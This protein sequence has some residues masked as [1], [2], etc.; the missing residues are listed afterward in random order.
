[1]NNNFYNTLFENTVQPRLNLGDIL[2][3]PLVLLVLGNIFYSL[4]LLLKFKILADTIDSEG[5]KKLKTL[6]YINIVVATI[7]GI[8]GTFIIILG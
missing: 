8:L 5:T 4:M 7:V 2:K 3:V 6:V 1:M